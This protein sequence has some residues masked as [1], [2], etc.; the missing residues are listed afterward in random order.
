LAK[1][2]KIHEVEGSVVELAVVDGEVKMF[3]LPKREKF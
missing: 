3:A 2:S 1:D